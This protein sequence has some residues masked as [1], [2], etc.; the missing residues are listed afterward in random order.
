PLNDVRVRR[1]LN[2]AVDKDTIASV[3]LQ[4]RSRAA[5][6]GAVRG[7]IGYDPELEPYAFDPA[8]ARALLKEAGWEQGFALDAEV[9]ISSNANDGLIYQF[10][11]DNLAKVGVTLNLIPI[12]TPQMMRVINQGEWKGDA[13]SQ[14]FGSWPTFDPIRT[15]RLHSCLWPNPWYCD[16][17][18]T[19]VIRAAMAEFD[20]A[21]RAELTRQILR[22]YHDEASALLLHEIPLLDGVAP[23][24][25]NYAPQKGKINYDT[26]A[27]TA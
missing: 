12:P 9:I 11:A 16:E 15:I 6:Q 3:I 20:L 4:G 14:V 23:R 27:V 26:I 8:K 1:A 17:R 10:V 2:H 24:V 19:P 18:I 13:F 7:L 21:K 22:F 25:R 5:T